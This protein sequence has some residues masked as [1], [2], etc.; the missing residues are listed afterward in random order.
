MEGALE[1]ET[2]LE[3][4]Y[5]YRGRILNLRVDSVR[6][7][8]GYRAEREVVEH[9]H[10]VVIVPLDSEG[11]VLLVRQYRTPPARFLLEAPAGGVEEGE[12]PEECVHR[13]L[14]EETGYT[15][16]KLQRLGSFWMVPG[17]CTEYM[18][19]YLATDLKAGDA[20]PEEDETLELVRV[21]KPDITDLIRSGEIQDSKSI[22]A[23]LMA[24][25]L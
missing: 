17:F 22:S 21:P 7:P 15:A 8:S 6:M 20:E 11:Y 12:T 5:I 23:L 19:A 1:P 24:F 2:T 25:N 16:G 13:E 9:G 4:K 10:S 14:K 18:H 3:S